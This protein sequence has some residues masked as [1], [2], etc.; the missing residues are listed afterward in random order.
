MD[1]KDNKPVKS[2]KLEILN[3]GIDKN[4]FIVP[5]NNNYKKTEILKDDGRYL[6]YYDFS[7]DYELDR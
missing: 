7:E 4:A 5:K 6:I 3:N 2:V 1:I